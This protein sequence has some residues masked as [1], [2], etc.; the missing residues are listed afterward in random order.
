MKQG[1]W[2]QGRVLNLWGKS[3]KPRGQN[4]KPQRIIPRLL[5][6]KLMSHLH[7]KIAWDWWPFSFLPFSPFLN[8]NVYSC[9]YMPVPP[10]YF[11]SRLTCFLSFIGLTEEKLCLRMDYNQSFTHRWLDNMKKGG[12]FEVRWLNEILD[13]KLMWYWVE[14]FGD[15]AMGWM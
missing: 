15:V 12:T 8:W 1:G 6:R 4:W 14:T 10:L 2:F 11:G 13:L 7:F 5:N 3:H 9:C